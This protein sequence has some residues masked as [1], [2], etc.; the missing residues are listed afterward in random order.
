M[1]SGTDPDEPF[2]PGNAGTVAQGCEVKIADLATGEPLGPNQ[3]G[4]ICVR[5]SKLFA[6]YL[7][8]EK[9]SLEAFDRDGWYRTGD[10]G[11][12][13]DRER[14][15]IT[16]RLKEVVRIGI[17]NHYINISPVEIEMYLL[18]HPAIAELAV[19]G[20]NNKAGTHWPRAYVVLKPDVTGVTGEQIEKFVSGSFYKLFSFYGF[21]YH[22]NVYTV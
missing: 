17:D 14:I 19:V 20:I 7:H 5:G 3:D 13:D 2:I 18:T 12:Y 9:A 1:T 15:F 6:G 16:D 11:H 10:I 21:L 8:N 4:E 22:N